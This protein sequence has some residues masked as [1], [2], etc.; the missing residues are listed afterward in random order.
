MNIRR[1][2]F[3]ALALVAAS[4]LVLAGCSS[5][6]DSGGGASGGDAAAIISTNGSE[7]QNP[8]IPTNTNEVGGGKILDE[9]FAG[10]V[11]YDAKGAPENDVAESIESDDAQ[12][13]TIT[14]KSGLTF[15]NG[16][17]VTSSSFIDAWNY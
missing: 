16:D 10:L 14:I 1:Y 4:T 7:P 6:N 2:G 12:N 3:G 5:S 11:Y 8:L 13:Y 15:T 9:I 17:P